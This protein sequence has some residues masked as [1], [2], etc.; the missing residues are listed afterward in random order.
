MQT[1]QRCYTSTAP[2]TWEHYSVYMRLEHKKSKKSIIVRL[3]AKSSRPNYCYHTGRLLMSG[4][5]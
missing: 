5:V 4:V 1:V 2:L 3:L